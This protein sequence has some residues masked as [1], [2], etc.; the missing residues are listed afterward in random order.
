MPTLL[1]VRHGRTAANSTGVLAGRSP[2]VGL[3]ERGAAQAAALPDRLAGIP[4]AALVHS[5]LQRCRETVEPV[6]AARP[7]VPVHA[8]DRV[9]ECDYGDWTGRKLAELLTEPLMETVQWHPS[10]VTFPGG[11]AMAAMAHR[12]AAAVRDWDERIG[13]EHGPDAI[14]LMC[15][16]GDI[17]KSIVADA[18]GLHLDLFQRITAGP[19][20]VTAIR[21]TPERPFVLRLG[22][23][24]TLDELAPAPGPAD[25]GGT[26][27]T[28]TADGTA[29]V[30][31]G[32]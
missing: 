20:S 27:A 11:E 5:P 2:G 16:H 4:L 10:A 30:G 12:A 7:G 17:I 19:A 28:G 31:G 22:D 25:G 1:L 13:R 24:G 21:Y 14:W 8:E 6:R 32:S 15:T 26:T 9:I 3:D 29:A 23:T 18:L